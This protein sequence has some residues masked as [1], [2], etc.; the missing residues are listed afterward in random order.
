MATVFDVAKYIL[1]RQGS[2]SSWK[3]QKLCY[4]S[5][6]WALAWTE[7]EL[8]PEDFEAWSNGP[9]CSVLFREHKGLFMVN[10]SDITKGTPENLT[11][12]E[13]D[14][15][16]VVLRDYGGMSPYELRELSHSEA[17][18]IEARHGLP[19]GARCSSVISKASM[20][21]FYRRRP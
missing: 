13:Q 8:F 11:H 9:V 7:H 14:T 15:V 2:M 6:A 10:A 3:L 12:D 20:G 16:D 1:K 21:A 4:Y 17:P 18:Y 19:D 5:Q